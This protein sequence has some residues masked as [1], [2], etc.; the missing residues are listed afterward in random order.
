METPAGFVAFGHVC[1]PVGMLKTTRHITSLIKE[2]DNAHRLVQ[3]VKQ[4]RA[5]SRDEETPTIGVFKTIMPQDPTLPIDISSSSESEDEVCSLTTRSNA[6]VTNS[7]QGPSTGV[8]GGMAAI[9]FGET[10]VKKVR[11]RILSSLMFADHVGYKE[12][13]LTPLLSTPTPASKAAC[14]FSVSAPQTSKVG[15]RHGSRL[16]W[17]TS[18]GRRR[19]ITFPFHPTA[20]DMSP[21][22]VLR[23]RRRAGHSNPSLS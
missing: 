3:Q 16:D 5:N 11:C 14:N 7:D 23:R 22:P 12:S 17:L 2:L 19:W 15:V 1:F 4:E 10:L 9:G 6:H 18:N 21:T 8:S 13:S 20:S